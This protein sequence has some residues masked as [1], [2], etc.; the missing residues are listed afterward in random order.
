VTKGEPAA[1]N[2]DEGT[3]RT[4]GGTPRVPALDGFRA[5]ALLAIVLMHL[6]G[7]SGILAEVSGTTQGVVLWSVFGNSIDA[8]FMISGFVLFLPTVAR[9]GEFGTAAAFW[10]YRGARLLPAY[11]L[12]MAAALLALV[13]FPPE[14]VY[15]VPSVESIAAHLTVMQSPIRIFDPGVV[16]G[17][18]LVGPVWMISV[19]VCFYLLLPFVARPYFRHPLVGLAVAAAITAGWKGAVSRVPQVFEAVSDGSVSAL[20]VGLIAVDQF[21]GWAFSFGL[22]LTG[23]WAYYWLR[24]RYEPAQLA[25]AA[26]RLAPSILVLY[27]LGAY[28]YGNTTLVYPGR[29]GPTARS[30]VL[31]TMFGSLSRAALIGIVILGPLWMQ[32]PFV[33]RVTGR[34][35]ELSYGIYLIHIPLV[36][37]AASLLD[38]PRDGSLGALAIW[39]AVIVPPSLL[40][41]ALSRRYVEQP[42]LRSVKRRLRPSAPTREALAS[43]G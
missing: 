33:N 23:A 17:F 43:L 29:I 7:A 39:V 30:E 34:L 38:L 19:V 14:S 20:T 25:R 3:A 24:E 11:W 40:F 8:F 2:P 31:D 26:L 22:G 18:G 41:A 42:I 36:I 21:P 6:I 37:Y 9:G 5:Y 15:P 32:R 28:L 27:A 4:A 1:A 10:I 16:P 13:L 35:A 12:V